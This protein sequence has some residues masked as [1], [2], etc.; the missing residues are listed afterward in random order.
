MKLI[1]LDLLFIIFSSANLALAFNTLDD[2]R[3]VC[4]VSGSS[5]MYTSFEVGSICRRQRGLVSFLLVATFLWVTA[6]T[7]SIVRVVERVTTAGGPGVN[8]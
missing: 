8:V 7:I 5:S 4:L 1:M 6:F 2:D 3:W